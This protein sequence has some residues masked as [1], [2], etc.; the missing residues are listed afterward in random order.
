MCLSDAHSYTTP[1]TFVRFTVV[2][3]FHIC[4]SLES[5]IVCVRVRVRVTKNVDMGEPF[6]IRHRQGTGASNM[7]AYI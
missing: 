5:G 6:V 3:Q 2:Q 7:C 1:T 4:Y